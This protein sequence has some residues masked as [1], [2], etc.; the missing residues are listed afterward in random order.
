MTNN[1]N[2]EGLNEIFALCLT[3]EVKN[4]PSEMDKIFYRKKFNV[5][6]DVTVAVFDTSG[7]WV[8]EF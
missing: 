2:Y 4:F 3:R 1:E 8:T 5:A 7:K 6:E